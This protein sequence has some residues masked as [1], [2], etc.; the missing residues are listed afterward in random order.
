MKGGRGEGGGKMGGEGREGKERR[1][2]KA[3]ERTERKAGDGREGRERSECI[4]VCGY[5][6]LGY[7]APSLSFLPAPQRW[8]ALHQ[9]HQQPQ[10][11]SH[12]LPPRAST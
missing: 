9:T 2:M 7:A 10:C 4:G 1:G 3:G 11:H 5:E 6:S 12:N 8:L